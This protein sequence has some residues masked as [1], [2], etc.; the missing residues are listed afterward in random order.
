MFRVDDC[1][2]RIN[3]RGVPVIGTTCIIKECP[4]RPKEECISVV[5]DKWMDHGWNYD[6]NKISK[7]VVFVQQQF[8]SQL[9]WKCHCLMPVSN[10]SYVSWT[11]IAFTF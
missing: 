10:I 2:N 8:T 7:T 1:I 6:K 9:V 4:G 3:N 5:L 11:S